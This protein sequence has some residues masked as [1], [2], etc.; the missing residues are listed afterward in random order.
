MG[1]P[2]PSAPLFFPSGHLCSRGFQWVLCSHSW[3]E[4]PHITEKFQ[5]HGWRFWSSCCLLWLSTVAGEAWAKQ[6]VALD[7]GLGRTQP[8]KIVS[9]HSWHR[10]K[11]SLRNFVFPVTREHLRLPFLLLAESAFGKKSCDEPRT[12]I[13]WEGRHRNALFLQHL[14]CQIIS[15][16]HQEEKSTTSLSGHLMLL[17]HLGHFFFPT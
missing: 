17:I 1:H 8:Y 6:P 14:F 13:T 12:F 4:A 9:Y 7:K 16:K 10:K 2:N 3:T 11:A 15:H 5:Q